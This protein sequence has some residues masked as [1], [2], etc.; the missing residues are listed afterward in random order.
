MKK[1]IAAF[2]SV[3]YAN[4]ANAVLTRYGIPAKVSRT[5]RTLAGGCGY[6]VTAECSAERLKRIL[7]EN[8]I[9]Y[10]SISEAS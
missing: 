1:H 4:K 3:T 5:P 6:S 7:D 8:G 10:K 9:T 2:A